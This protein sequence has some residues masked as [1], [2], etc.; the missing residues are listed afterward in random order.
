MNP[1]DLDMIRRMEEIRADLALL[2]QRVRAIA[3]VLREH[4]KQAQAL[5]RP[6]VP[7]PAPEPAPRAESLPTRILASG[8]PGVA[9]LAIVAAPWLAGVLIWLLWATGTPLPLLIALFGASHVA[10]SSP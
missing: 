2:H 5:P 3:I 1:T 8:W 6:P 7:P 9:A 4:H 10:E